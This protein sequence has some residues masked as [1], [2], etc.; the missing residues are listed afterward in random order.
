ME[1]ITKRWF[2]THAL[3]ERTLTAIRLRSAIAATNAPKIARTIFNASE[4]TNDRSMGMAHMNASDRKLMELCEAAT[5]GPKFDDYAGRYKLS[6][7]LVENPERVK[8]LLER[9]ERLLNGLI[10]I[11]EQDC[12]IPMCTHRAC[13]VAALARAVVRNDRAEA[14]KWK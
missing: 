2:R 7:Y 11:G 10:K 6:A 8:S 3:I 5:P 4:Q 12:V 9:I 13:A 14:A 1:R